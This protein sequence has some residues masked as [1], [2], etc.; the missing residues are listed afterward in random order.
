MP[1]PITVMPYS[2]ATF[3]VEAIKHNFDNNGFCTDCGIYQPATLN[4]GVYEI[5][6][7]GQL[8]WFASLV[9][10]DS[11]HAEFDAQ[12]TGANAVL[13]KDINLESREWSPIMNFVGTFDGDNHTI[14]NG[15][16]TQY[17]GAIIGW[18]RNYTSANIDNNYYLDS[19]SSLAFGSGS[20]SG[21]TATAKTAEQFK[22]GEVAYL[23]NHSVTDGTQVWY[24][25]L[26]NGETPDDYPVFDG[27]TVYYLEYKD[28]YSNTYSEKPE[29][30]EFDK[31][32]DDNFI[33]RTYDDL[34]Q[35]FLNN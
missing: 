8:F 22:S 11:T 35:L 15:D 13:V 23:L 25:N 17:C 28:G 31:D 27:G 19:S 12:N 10:G 29:T 33:I 24:Q 20:K 32:D 6:N 3:E 14:S 2:D 7:A 18:A 30:Y 21:V 5:S 9:N 1:Y 4:G 16:S 34:N 26:D